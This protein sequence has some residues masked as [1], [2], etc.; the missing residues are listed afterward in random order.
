MLEQ[1][2]ENLNRQ[3]PDTQ[4]LDLAT[5]RTINFMIIAYAQQQYLLLQKDDMADMAK[6]AGDKSVGAINYGDKDDLRGHFG[7]SFESA[8]STFTKYGF[9]RGLATSVTTDRR[10]KR[11]FAAQQT[12][13]QRPHLSRRS[14]KT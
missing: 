12:R 11:S 5:K 4:G 3:P 2:E 1:L 9:C 14:S 7:G 6:Q 13:C 8:G 10:E